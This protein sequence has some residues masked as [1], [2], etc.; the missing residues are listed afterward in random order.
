ME[1]ASKKLIVKYGVGAIAAFTLAGITY[2]SSIHAQASVFIPDSGKP[3]HYNLGWGSHGSGVS[4]DNFTAIFNQSGDYS[5]GD[6]F[7]QTFADDGVKVEVDGTTLINRW[8]DYKGKVN[9]AL[10]LNV[11]GGHHTVKTHYLENVAS[12][13]IYSDIVPFDSWVAYYYSNNPLKVCQLRQRSL[14]LLTA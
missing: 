4:P 3:V 13:A 12:A 1:I 6:Y 10:W 11:T 9:R 14:H 2:G 7:L 8:G 5:S